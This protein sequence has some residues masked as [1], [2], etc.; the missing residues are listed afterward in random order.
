MGK[1]SVKENK[2]V[3]Q[4]YREEAELTR[5][6]ASEKMVFIS[7]S[8]IDKVESEKSPIHP[9]EV[10]AMSKA[11]KRPELCNY[12]CSN[13]CPIGI[14]FVPEVRIK[15]L[16]Q[17]VLEMLA[18]IN[19]LHRQKDRLIEI[20]EDGTI[21]DDEL[22]DFVAIQKGLEKISL[23]ADTLRLWMDNTIASGNI[24]QK[25]LESILNSGK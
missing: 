4:L 8:R 25:K 6:Q 24:D 2:N 1:K 10:L 18:S 14:E 20:T 3:Y 19:T 22:R 16:S 7:E 5:A 11:Y 13:E 9:E 21:D 17:I 12:Y 15:D 23:V